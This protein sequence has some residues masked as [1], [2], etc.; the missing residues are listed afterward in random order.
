M[1]NYVDFFDMPFFQK[2][3]TDE[4]KV[5]GR[6]IL[7]FIDWFSPTLEIKEKLHNEMIILLVA[8]VHREKT[9]PIVREYYKK[10]NATNSSAEWHNRETDDV[11]EIMS[12]EE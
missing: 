10:Q 2:Y 3:L 9:L 6:T 1:S 7:N 12:K 11:I 4:E 5:A 8:V